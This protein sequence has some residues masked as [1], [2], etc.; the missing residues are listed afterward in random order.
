M[1]CFQSVCERR[2]L[3]MNSNKCLRTMYGYKKDSSTGKY[4]ILHHQQLSDLG[5][6]IS[7]IEVGRALK[8]VE[9]K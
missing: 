3:I 7:T 5:L 2:Y 4:N 6:D 9:L 8:Y 1:I